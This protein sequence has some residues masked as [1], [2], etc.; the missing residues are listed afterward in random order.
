MKTLAILI[1][2]LPSL[3]LCVGGISNIVIS[4]SFENA[5]MQPENPRTGEDG[6]WY[7]NKAEQD[8][9]I[10]YENMIRLYPMYNGLGTTISYLLFLMGFG[11]LGSIIRILLNKMNANNPL[12]AES[13]IPVVG[14][15]IGIVVIVVDEFLPEFKYQSGKEK[16]YFTMALLG[17]LYSKEFL[18]SLG[19]KF[20]AR[21][22][23][24][25]TKP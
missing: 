5:R 21:L 13:L 2:V 4:K 9:S 17:G 3:Y 23:T 7:R 1:W 18:E 10:D 19:K 22:D 25:P 14:V 11:A 8:A 16:F 12:P 24:N 15:I 20:I 6:N